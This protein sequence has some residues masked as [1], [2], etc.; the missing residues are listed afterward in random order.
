MALVKQFKE[1][2]RAES[3][4]PKLINSLLEQV[5][6]WHSRGIKVYGLRIPTSAAMRNVE[7]EYSQFNESGFIDDFS[8]AGGIWIPV[9]IDGYISYDGSH[10]RADSAVK[11]S[12]V[13]GEFIEHRLS[14]EVG[15][16]SADSI[17]DAENASRLLTD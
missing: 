10:L 5:Q 16:R 17:A 2:A 15:K 8:K 12:K 14:V 1:G 3:A 4:N 7:N 11:L 13:V 9:E 6:K